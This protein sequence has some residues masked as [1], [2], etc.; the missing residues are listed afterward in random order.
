MK[1]YLAPLE[2]I[3]LYHVR[4][5]YHHHF[6]PADKY[7]VP[8]VV[9]RPKK[10][11]SNRERMDLLPEHNEGMATV[12][13]ILTKHAEDFLRMEESLL[14]WGYQEIN[15]NVGCPS[16]TVVSK[17]RG[18]GMLADP[19]EL[20][21]FLEELFAHTKAKISVKT[22]IGME[23]AGEF[24]EILAVY[25]QY[26]LEELIIHPRVREQFYKG[27]PDWDCFAYAWENSR[28]PV[29]YNGDIFDQ[30]D[31]ERLTERFPGLEGIML[32]R[33]VL[34]DPRLIGTLR[35]GVA[36]GKRMWKSYH[37][38]IIN[39]YLA[40]GVEKNNVLYKMKEIWFYLGE[41][42]PKAEKEKKQIKK[43]QRLEELRS[44]AWQIFERYGGQL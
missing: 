11:F 15:L 29:I 6:E 27:R 44:I 36:A 35:T 16:G 28:N 39:S 23:S 19:R 8:F 14:Q 18:A 13:Q 26:P 5:A 3:T 31:Y 25:N 22:R 24:R 30:A 7:F 10:G 12:P 37:D 41:A 40:A 42:F 20:D 34:Q 9:P 1:F 32:G 43:A 21:R 33:G 38:E 2:G 17:G 4:N